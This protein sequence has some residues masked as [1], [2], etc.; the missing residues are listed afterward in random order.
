VTAGDSAPV[1]TCH[2]T[3]VGEGLGGSRFAHCQMPTL[4]DT[5]YS[6]NETAAHASGAAGLPEPPVSSLGERTTLGVLVSEPEG[7]AVKLPVDET[8]TD[9]VRLPVELAV[10]RSVGTSVGCE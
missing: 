2:K 9:A 6:N 10:C 1:T 4:N 3:T 5:G 8:D 7:V